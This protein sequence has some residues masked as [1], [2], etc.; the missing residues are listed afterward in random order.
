MP[1][2]DAHCVIPVKRTIDHSVRWADDGI[3]DRFEGM[4]D[5]SPHC[6][7]D[8]VNIAP[9]FI[10]IAPTIIRITMYNV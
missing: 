6:K 5:K 3:A 8:L 4:Q 7:I 9:K 2:N 1:E 10:K